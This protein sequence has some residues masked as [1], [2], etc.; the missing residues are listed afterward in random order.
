[1]TSPRSSSILL[2][3]ILALY[4]PSPIQGSLGSFRSWGIVPIS[5]NRFSSTIPSGLTTKS[6][7]KE[8]TKTKLDQA[9]L[10][11]PNTIRGGQAKKENVDAVVRCVGTVTQFLISAGR[12]IL[13]PTA[14][15]VQ[16]V[17]NFY[18]A[19]PIDAVVAQVGLVYCFAGG[20]Y[21]TLFS[22]VQAAQM[23]GLEV[24]VEA[25]HELTDEAIK[26]IDATSDMSWD[27]LDRKDLFLRQTN[28]VLKTVDPVKIN[29][30]AAALYTTWLGVS[31]VLEKEY[32]RVISLSMTL[33]RYFEIVAI[34]ILE[35]PVKFVVGEDYHKW[36]TVVI[37]W[38]CKAV[39]MNIAWRIQRVLTASTSAMVGGVMFSRALLRMLHRKGVT[40]FGMVGETGEESALDE[41]IGFSVAG[42]GFWTQIQSQY[43]NNFSFEVP[44]PFSLVT[45]PFDWAEKWIQW[46]ITK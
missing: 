4:L 46:Q 13:P 38:G 23:C 3:L 36:V 26:V 14:A 33:A 16:A 12:T 21:P 19:L 42:L 30:A 43:K 5:P 37:G 22:C 8:I 45:W 7:L 17:V 29:Q 9:L 27:N 1:M 41:I 11:A 15:A 39:A 2:C 28:I 6:T 32:A 10:V 31:A 20:Y 34:R 18:R 24:M 44:F 35:P 25:I 40:F